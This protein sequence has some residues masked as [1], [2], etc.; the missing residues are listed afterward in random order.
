M[1]LTP[2]PAAPRRPALALAARLAFLT[3]VM[4]VALVLG[5]TEIALS[6]SERSRLA[7]SRRE[8]RALASALA[9]YLTR[10]AP[11]GNRDSLEMEFRRWAHQDL[12][13]IEATVFL[14][15]GNT[16]VAFIA[17]D[18]SL[19]DRAPSRLNYLALASD[20]ALDR[21]ETG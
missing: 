18:S 9:S 15:E 11:R 21:F 20:S 12:T 19:L 16:L 1:E 3:A 5:A 7:D 13:G 10:I 17:V 8:S 2:S 14:R 6:W 4:A